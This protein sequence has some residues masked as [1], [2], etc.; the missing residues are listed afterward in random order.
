MGL[1]Q[2]ER[3][4]RGSPD[5]KQCGACRK[6]QYEH[7][8]NRKKVAGHRVNLCSTCFIEAKHDRLLY[9]LV[10]IDQVQDADVNRELM[11]DLAAEHRG[12]N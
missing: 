3:I 10:A 11:E 2:R 12:T 6:E 7:D 9:H 1:R 5:L 8:V 4:H